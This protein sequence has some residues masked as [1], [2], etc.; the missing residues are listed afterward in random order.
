MLQKPLHNRAVCRDYFIQIVIFSKTGEM[1]KG[2]G[3]AHKNGF[4][5]R[6]EKAVGNKAIFKYYG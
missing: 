2:H 3:K 5:Q 1:K 6:T 4:I